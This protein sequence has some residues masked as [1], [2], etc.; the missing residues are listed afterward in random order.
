MKAFGYSEQ[1]KKKNAE[2]GESRE[3]ASEKQS[4]Q[5]FQTGITDVFVYSSF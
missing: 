1:Q 5:L 4:P 3:R 2:R